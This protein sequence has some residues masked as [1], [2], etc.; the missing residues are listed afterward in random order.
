MEIHEKPSKDVIRKQRRTAEK[1]RLDRIERHI[2][3]CCDPTKPK[4]ASR[5]RTIRAWKYLQLRLRELGLSRKGGVYAT[6]AN[7]LDICAGGPMA[8]VY[9]EGVWY[10]HCDPPVLERILQEHLIGGRIVR[11]Y[12]ILKHPLPESVLTAD[13]L[14]EGEE[15]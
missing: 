11:E 7:C 5:K 15:D 6:R 4:C 9:P 3:L 10:G 2:F 13:E 12:R 1:L 8:V 14:G